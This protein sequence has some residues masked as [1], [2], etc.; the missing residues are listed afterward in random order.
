MLVHSV[1]QKSTCPPDLQEQIATIVYAAPRCEC[2]ELV[3]LKQ[4][5]VHRVGKEFIQSA[6][7]N[8]NGEVNPRVLSL[9]FRRALVLCSC[10]V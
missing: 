3:K 8:Q 10:N 5:L 4:L 1:K 7:D 6:A 2:E 9:S